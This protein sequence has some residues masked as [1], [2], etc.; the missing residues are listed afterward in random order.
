MV[1]NCLYKILILDTSILM[2]MAQNKHMHD[3][4]GG[5]ENKDELEFSQEEERRGGTGSPL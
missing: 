5:K 3:F 1:K 2:W 4:C